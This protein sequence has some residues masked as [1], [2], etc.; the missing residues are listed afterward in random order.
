M[1]KEKYFYLVCVVVVVCLA[2]GLDLISS[3]VAVE[4]SNKVILNATGDKVTSLEATFPLWYQVVGLLKNFLY[5][6]GAAIFITVFI[7]NRLQKTLHEEKQE[8]L[9]KLNDA[10]S[11]NVFDSLFKAII[12]EEIFKIIKREIIQ[13][14][15]LRKEAKWIYDFTLR[16]DVIICRQTTRYELHNLS[17]EEVSNP[18]KLN[19]DALGGSIYNLV[20]AE[21]H[22]QFGEVLVK[23]Y[24][25]DTSKNINIDVERDGNKLTVSYSVKIPAKSY[26]E[27]NTV[28]E[29]S[30][31]GDITDAQATKVPVVG[32]DIIVNFPEGYH[33]DISPLMSTVPRLI[34]ESSIQKIFRVEGGVLPNQGFIFYLVK[35]EIDIVVDDREAVVSLE[36][37]E[38]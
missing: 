25:D 7:A 26:A 29:K 8:E 35:K 16:G 17:N 23:Y 31:R 14:K 33:F 1:V 6:L 10:I 3:N 11:V 15:V 4:I 37:P 13:N 20:S 36:M 22:S 18:I 2:F 5:G 27:Y 34:S 24:P 12:P 19:L 38:V 28:F 21:C 32:A 9:N 30:Y